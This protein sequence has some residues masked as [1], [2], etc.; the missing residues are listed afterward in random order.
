MK[1]RTISAASRSLACAAVLC[2][3]AGAAQAD[4]CTLANAG[5]QCLIN[6]DASALGTG[7]FDAFGD[8]ISGTTLP[9]LTWAWFDGLDATGALVASGGPSDPVDFI[10]SA[11]DS[12]EPIWDDGRASALLTLT[13]DGPTIIFDAFLAFIDSSGAEHIVAGT[14]GAPVSTPNALSLLAAALLGAGAA[15]GRRL[16][17]PGLHRAAGG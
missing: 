9:P 5:D 6:W 1:Q 7:P 2:L 13:V 17:R 12:A 4:V 16:R 14:P 15:T 11:P 8:G 3:A 10:I